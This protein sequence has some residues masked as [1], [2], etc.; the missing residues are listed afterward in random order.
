MTRTHLLSDLTDK[1]VIAKREARRLLLERPG[2]A[3]LQLLLYQID[4]VQGEVEAFRAGRESTRETIW[5]HDR[6]VGPIWP[7]PS[8]QDDPAM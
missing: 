8:G 1:L 7:S 5:P 3:E 4:R 2:S 6:A